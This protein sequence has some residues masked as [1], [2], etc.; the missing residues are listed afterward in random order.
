MP[1]ESSSKFVAIVGVMAALTT[2]ATMIVQIPT[3]ATKGYINLGDTMVM[4]AGSLF[5]SLAGSI[6]GGV[7]SALADLLSGYGH[8]APFTLV[9]KGIE[10]YIA[11]L[12]RERRGLL[13][14]L[15]LILAGAEMVL[16]Y[17]L[18]EVLLYGLGGALAEVPGNSF[19]AVSGVVFAY[20]LTPVVRRVL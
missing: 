7:G 1:R 13:K 4:L 12:S 17:F 9:I 2:V 5:G 10:G 19:Q 8:W 15:I 11:G 20:I 18:V 14:L 3:P 16:G 6:A